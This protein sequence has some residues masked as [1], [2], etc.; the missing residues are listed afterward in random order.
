V[1]PLADQ[2]QG[3]LFDENVAARLA[4]DLSG[5]FPGS[6][7]VADAGL[8]AAAD[9]AIWHYAR[10]NGFALVTKDQDFHRLSVLH[11][12]PPKVIWLRLGNCSTDDIARLLRDRRDEIVAFLQH[13]EAGFLALG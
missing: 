11:G 13:D 3:L 8:Q 12:P 2:P 5:V 9:L 1:S 6:T 4:A 7:H 10:D